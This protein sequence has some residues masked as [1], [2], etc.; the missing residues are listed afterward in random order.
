[1]DVTLTPGAGPK[2]LL[3]VNMLKR[4]SVSKQK[5]TERGGFAFGQPCLVTGQTSWT[6]T[7]RR[8]EMGTD[9]EAGPFGGRRMV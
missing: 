6:D 5:E 7:S 1:M 4:E 8:A 9:G 3:E 2:R